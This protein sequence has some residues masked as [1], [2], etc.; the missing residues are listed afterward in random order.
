MA[1]NV[2]ELYAS[3]GIETKGLDKQISSIEQK[4]SNIAKGLTVGGG[5]MSAAITAP[6]VKAGKAVY[7]A[8]TDFESQ[9]SRVE[10]ISGASG[11]SL[12]ALTQK[13]LEMGST[14]QFTAT[15]AG[16]ALEYMAMAGWKDESMLAG[17][18]PV[19]NLAAAS[20]GDLA[21]TS[22]IVTD[23]M[24]AFGYTLESVGGDTQAFNKQITHF[25]DVLA[26]VSTNANT[27]VQLMGESFK[28]VAPLAGTLGYSV[29]D[30][31][32][33]L[34]TMA[35]AGIK[36]S[37]AGTSL[38]R[39]I[40]NMISPT[41]KQA[42]AMK[43]LGLSLYDSNGKIKSFS[44]VMGD[45]R[46][47]AKESGIDLNQLQKDVGELD[48][49]L[50]NGE[51]T[52]KQYDK[53]VKKLTKGNDKFL[54]AVS[55][56]AGARGL[57]GM[58][59]IMNASDA[60]FDALTESILHCDGATA[61]MAQTMLDNAKGDVTIFKSALEGLE[62]TLWT[63]VAGP[64]RSIVQSATKIVDAFRKMNSGTQI[65]VLKMAG[66]AAAAG[67]AMLAIGRIVKLAPVMGKVLTSLIS[68]LGIVTA[69]L[70]L[71]AIAAVDANNDIGKAFLKGSMAVGA[72]LDEMNKNIASNME[73]V[74]KRMPKLIKMLNLGLKRVIP[75]ITTT[76]NEIVK[77][78]AKAI[79]DNADGIADLG[80]TVVEGVVN[81]IADGLPELIPAIGQAG[82]QIGTAILGLIPRI[83]TLAGNLGMAIVN[84]IINT[85]WVKMGTDLITA[86]GNAITDS[87][88]NGADIANKLV[89]FINDNL[90]P[91]N[92]STL[93]TNATTFA[94]TLFT[95]I[96]ESFGTV[97]ENGVNIVD[98]I[99]EAINGVLGTVTGTEFTGK[100]SGLATAVINGI[101]SSLI[102]I[103]TAGSD[104]LTSVIDGITT[105]LGNITSTSFDNVNSV[106]EAIMGAIS[107]GIGKIGLAG[108]DI[109]TKL[110]TAI[111]TL[112]STITSSNFTAGAGKLAETIITGLGDAI[113]TAFS[114]AG[115]IVDAITALISGAISE[116]SDVD[117]TNNLAGFGT[118][119]IN[120]IASAIEKAATGAADLIT[121]IGNLISTALNGNTIGNLGS[122]GIAIIKA[123]VNGIKSAGNAAAMILTAIGNAIS[124]V[125]WSKVGSDLTTLGASL[126]EVLAKELTSQ[127]FASIIT[128]IGTGL[129]NAVGGL[130]TAAAT[131]VHHLV[132]YLLD[133]ANWS[134]LGSGFAAILETA[135]GSM[136]EVL[137]T[138]DQKVKDIVEALFGLQE[139]DIDPVEYDASVMA[140]LIGGDYSVQQQL[141]ESMRNQEPVEVEVP[142]DAK[143]TVEEV[144]TPESSELSFEEKLQQTYDEKGIDLTLPEVSAELSGVTV[145]EGEGT[146]IQQA[147]QEA[148]DAVMESVT[149][150]SDV[151]V[152]ANVTVTVGDNNAGTIGTDLGTELGTNFTTAIG[153]ATGMAAAQAVALANRAAASLQG[154]Y[155]LAYTAGAN[156]GQGFVNG[157]AG[158]LGAV[159]A[160]ALELARAAV[161][162]LQA[163]IAQGSP[164]K[165][166][167]ESGEFFGEGFVRGIAEKLKAVR[168][169]S[170]RMAQAAVDAL[171]P[172]ANAM[173]FSAQ[174]RTDG[175]MTSGFG[176]MVDMMR[177]IISAIPDGRRP[178]VLDSGALVGGIANDMNEA[179]GDIAE[180]RGGSYA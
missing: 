44:D 122:F 54:K 28:Y 64:F 57:S 91:E 166:T 87:S 43:K 49:Q 174:N 21:S 169:E 156:F 14:T 7:K 66:L 107:M 89:T 50:A 65:A 51:I 143:A 173:S 81:G 29:D 58:L 40:Q 23:A 132:S 165:I 125:D 5:V 167:F 55:D 3:F 71:F 6:L 111:G 147:T 53:A 27:N 126:V 1:L 127:D 37:Q 86:I 142:I 85:D 60:E 76:A 161:Q 72:H 136:M 98:K 80:M 138:I 121:A 56:L 110:G 39:I 68:P 22:D 70:A 130:A 172:A 158:K 160:K 146:G 90:T 155:S 124:G 16:Q 74:S 93:L 46:K 78:F 137:D 96:T 148:V 151:A 33:A 2:G 82:V 153:N 63:L 20:G 106:A 108:S 17:L 177:Q 175:L 32:V 128:K 61:K 95:T 163:G 105:V 38:Q 30:I 115:K 112:L 73:T 141:E 42:K 123:I 109:V 94:N 114:S 15:E 84:G 116:G 52:Q 4:C 135:F 103:G 145:T 18:E 83:V 19:M 104:I 149:F 34:G 102:A 12:A 31:A 157:M 48:K 25:S 170:S 11:D 150:T 133:P 35:N 67:P 119:V 9:M 168:T 134:G 140:G 77:G 117:L 176:Q 171:N 131:V 139:G 24:T 129:V 154:G 13:A 59:A 99:V 144:E 118:A 164:S 152:T 36:G 41:D 120:A 97:G 88:Q 92:M 69:G 62:I 79:G 47:A 113:G 159:R 75:S 101:V 180:R 26:A 10:A 100:L 162:S 8:G 45:M 179:L 178:I